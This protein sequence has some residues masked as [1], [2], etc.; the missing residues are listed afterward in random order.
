[1]NGRR[2]HANMLGGPGGTIEDELDTLR[3]NI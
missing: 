3:L 2:K 1:M